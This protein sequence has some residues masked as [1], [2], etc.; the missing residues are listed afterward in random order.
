[1]P[2]E[3]VRWP[4]AAQGNF[5][6]GSGIAGIEGAANDVFFLVTQVIIDKVG[7]FERIVNWTRRRDGTKKEGPRNPG[8]TPN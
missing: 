6:N 5:E 2:D 1:M 4:R 7:H 8:V 3:D